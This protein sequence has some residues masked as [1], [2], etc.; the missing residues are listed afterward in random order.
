MKNM[1]IERMKERE[2][3][4][5]NSIHRGDE[6]VPAIF[7]KDNDHSSGVSSSSSLTMGNTFTDHKDEE[8]LTGGIPPQNPH[9]FTFTSNTLKQILKKD[10]T[11]KEKEREGKKAIDHDIRNYIALK[12]R[13]WQMAIKAEQDKN[14][15]IDLT[16]HSQLHSNEQ[17]DSDN[18]SGTAATGNKIEDH[19]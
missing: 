9:I 12:Q 1:E 7:T 5:L 8:S 2:D 13:E 11:L 14:Q 6:M 17:D 10:L 4:D 16:K 3:D 19:E 18:S 15:T